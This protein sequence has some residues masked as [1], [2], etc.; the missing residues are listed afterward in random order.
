MLGTSYDD[1]WP[2][3]EHSGS[4]SVSA[5]PASRLRLRCFGSLV[6]QTGALPTARILT[7]SRIVLLAC[8]PS[9]MPSA[10][11]A[12]PRV[13]SRSVARSIRSLRTD[14]STA[15]IKFARSMRC[16]VINRQRASPPNASA[17]LAPR[18]TGRATIRG[19]TT[20][21]RASEPAEA[22]TIERRGRPHGSIHVVERTRDDPSRAEPSPERAERSRP[23]PLLRPLPS[24][25][26]SAYQR[27]QTT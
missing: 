22:R 8:S 23:F 16:C 25:I 10:G 4:S 5:P 17:T 19:P 6:S 12:R 21:A 26:R 24:F 15:S 18:R 7:S 27:R 20:D 14:L 9:R 11:C 13:G 1:A 2:N 3:S